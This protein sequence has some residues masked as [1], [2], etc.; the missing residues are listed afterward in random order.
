MGFDKDSTWFPVGFSLWKGRLVL[1]AGALGGQGQDGQTV[2][3][4]KGSRGQRRSSGSPSQRE[5]TERHW[6]STVFDNRER[7]E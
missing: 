2:R 1:F 3:G 6:V 4:R 5:W 7:I